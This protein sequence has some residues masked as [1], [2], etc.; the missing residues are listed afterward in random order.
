M[1]SITSRPL[2]I[3]CHQ[4]TSILA[5]HILDLVSVDPRVQ[6]TDTSR[7]RVE[8]LTLGWR[9]HADKMGDGREEVQG[10]QIILTRGEGTT[11]IWVALPVVME[12]HW[13]NLWRRK[14][15]RL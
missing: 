4:S 1:P 2:I 8:A 12:R 5:D 6:H 15:V 9:G 7:D 14:D 10:G 11:P 13:K 3:Q